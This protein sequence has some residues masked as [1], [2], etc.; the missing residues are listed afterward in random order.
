MRVA[1]EGNAA[2]LANLP[3]R[4]SVNDKKGSRLAPLF[5]LEKLG[6]RILPPA[7]KMLLRLRMLLG[8]VVLVCF[9]MRIFS[10]IMVRAVM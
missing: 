1:R 8:C 7:V 6:L 2:P 4:L 3:G 5:A 9:V 10:V